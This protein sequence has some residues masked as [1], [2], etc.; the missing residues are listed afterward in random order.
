MPLVYVASWAVTIVVA[1][2]LWSPLPGWAAVLSGLAAGFPVF[3][4]GA[5]WVSRREED[6]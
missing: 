1:A 2:V 4:A 5:F 3:V 6:I